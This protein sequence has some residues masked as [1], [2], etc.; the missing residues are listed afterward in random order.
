LSNGNS[1]PTSGDLIIQANVT[2]RSS[3]VGGQ[4]EFAIPANTDGTNAYGQGR[5]ITVAGNGNSNSATGK[6]LIGTRRYFDKYSTGAQWYYGDDVT[7]DG[8]GNVGIGT[9]NP[10]QK[11]TV[12]GTIHANEVLVDMTIQGP[13]Y[14]FEKKLQPSSALTT[15]DLHQSKQT[16][17]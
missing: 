8:V 10:D 7:I 4:L 16:L 14:V 1:S 5:I 15:R 3:T 6:M 11:L 17:T 2:G 9:T 13:D 12:K